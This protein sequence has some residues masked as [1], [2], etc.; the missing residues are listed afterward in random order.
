MSL[1]NN[2]SQKNHLVLVNKNRPSSFPVN[3]ENDCCENHLATE[4]NKYPKSSEL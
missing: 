4:S 2:I 3:G 1:L